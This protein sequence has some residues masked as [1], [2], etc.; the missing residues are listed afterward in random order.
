MRL[1]LDLAQLQL[2]AHGIQFD[3]Q[4]AAENPLPRVQLR[5]DDASRERRIDRVC[6]AVK[7]YARIGRDLVQ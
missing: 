3:E 4:V 6:C 1:H 5:R 2:L 7:L